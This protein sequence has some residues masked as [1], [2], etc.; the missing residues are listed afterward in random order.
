[1]GGGN[2]LNIIRNISY[3]THND[4]I[5]TGTLNGTIS[6]S[7]FNWNRNNY[8]FANLQNNLNDLCFILTSSMIYHLSKDST[9]YSGSPYGIRLIIE[10]KE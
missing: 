3:K 4:I 7:S 8:V 10:Y 5:L 1:M 6:S 9:T 2:S